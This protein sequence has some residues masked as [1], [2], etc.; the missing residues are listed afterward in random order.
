[1]AIEGPL[2]ELSLPDVLQL[3]QLSRKTGTLTVR[4]DRAA[5]PGLLFFDQ[6]AVV[7][8]R[9]PGETSRLGRLLLMA[10]KA[11]AGQIDRALEAQR[12]EPGRPIGEILVRE[13]GVSVAD[14]ERMLRFQVEEALSELMR[15]VE[16]YVRFEETPP[17]ESGPVRIRLSAESLLM[18][19]LRRVDEW[20]ELAS[21][22]PDASLVPRLVDADGTAD[23][24]LDLLPRE[25]EV[26]AA[27][28]GERT[29]QG[30]A[31]ELGHAEFDVAKALF[32]LVSAGVVELGKRAAR[33]RVRA[34]ASARNGA[35]AV[36]AAL[37]AGDTERAGARLDE[38]LA[39]EPERSDLH[40]LR[41]RVAAARGRWDEAV[42]AYDAAL[43]LD[44][45]M[46]AAYDALGRAA[47]RAG[48]LEHAE[49][50]FATFSRLADAP[51]A[52]RERAA[53]SAA[54]LAGL[55]RILEEE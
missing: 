15:W 5:R 46:A 1:M 10:G 34:A 4:T 6:G 36:E 31:R 28:D 25:W 39:R 51:P 9:A 37:D 29:L 41:G 38:L 14:V 30:I 54:L 24:V 43:R 53:R 49:E 11:T 33:A 22:Q 3:V 7:G 12:D 18:E 8:A 19:A 50:A 32:S 45:L 35:A 20:T 42:R 44:P 16:G 40:L 52:A 48:A 13:Q 23:G 27:I 21:G 55:R 47:V 17:L 2:R 26:L